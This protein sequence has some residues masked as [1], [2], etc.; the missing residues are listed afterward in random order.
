MRPLLGAAVV[1]VLVLPA[2]TG[3]GDAPAPRGTASP[4]TPT[5]PPTATTSARVAPVPA[6]APDATPLARRFLD[7]WV[8]PDGRVVRRD[9]GGDTT[10][11]GQAAALLL[12]VQ[13]DDPQLTALVWDWTAAHL[14]RP[15]GLLASRWADGGVADAAP[16]AAADLA[17]A[18]GLVAAGRR[19]ADPE[20][21][22]AGARLAGAV[23]DGE[24]A[25]T[26][27]GRVLLAD[28]AAAAPWPVEPGA[29]SP[30]A[31]QELAAAV[32][33]PRWAELETGSAAV[34]RTLLGAATLPPDAARVLAD[35]RVEAVASPGAVDVQFGSAAARVPVGSAASCDPADVAIA[36]GLAPA[37]VR[38]DDQVSGRYDTGGTPTVDYAQPLAFVAAA[39]AAAAAGDEAA[40]TRL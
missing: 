9:V 31:V 13:S 15:D 11:E 22:A 24:T 16:D 32:P 20:L 6:A 10:S 35:G 8:D 7:T 40:R 39:A 25:V 18:Q 34:L 37:L 30:L 17:S 28:P 3:G 14:Q 19:F 21:A 27:L 26:P 36:A 12:A 5:A 1:L 23:L 4:A 2:C 33:D 38:T 29:A